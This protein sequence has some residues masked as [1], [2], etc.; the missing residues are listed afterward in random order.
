MG[1]TLKRVPMDFDWPLKIVWKGY[2]SPYRQTD[3]K[4]CGGSGYNPE[5]R[6]LSDDWYDHN[7]TGGRWCDKLTQDE[8]DALVEAGRLRSHVDGKWTKIP[9]TA[10]EVN[11]ANRREAPWNG[12]LHHDGSNSYLCVKTR[13]E[14]L[15]VWGLCPICEGG[16]GFYCDPKYE[17]L[18][19][20]W[21][22]IEP[23]EGP[24]YQL[25]ETTSEGS[26]SSPVFATIEELC[27][28]CAEFATTFGRFKTTAEDWRKMLDDDFVYHEDGRGNMFL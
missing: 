4:A 28:W 9:R 14:R 2:C 11:K 22:Q 20:A 5:T 23:P 24:G 25:W 10:E 18:A 21:E 7:G 17:K 12:D 1:R 15:G 3:C 26:P 16:G 19:D 6:K 8:V 27:V 13:G